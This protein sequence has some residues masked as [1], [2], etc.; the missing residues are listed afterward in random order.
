MPSRPATAVESKTEWAPGTLLTLEQWA[1]LPE[2]VEGELV[3]GRL[4]E[5]EVGDLTHESA[6]SWLVWNLRNWLA[7]RGGG[8][9]FTSDAKFAVGRRRGRKPDVTVFLPGT[10]PP[11]RRGLVRVPPD[12]A[13]E[14]VSPSP[15]DERRDRVEKM[16]DY[17]SFGVRYY[18]LVDPM[19]GSLE[20]FELGPDRRYV[21][22]LGATSGRLAAIPGCAGLTL[23]L[24]AL[25]RDIDRLGPPEGRTKRR[26]RATP[27]RR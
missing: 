7:P 22:A 11:P 27:R 5:E 13:V 24:D 10:R 2:D 4:T 14:V 1:A 15:R 16:A 23:D 3:D 12:M 20:V 19:I 9:V 8:F 26:R 21:R 18:W 25:W 6:V 17:A